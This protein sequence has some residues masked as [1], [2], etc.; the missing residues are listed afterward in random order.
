MFYIYISGLEITVFNL[1]LDSNSVILN[2]VFLW[3]HG[4]T[5]SIR[6]LSRT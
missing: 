4:D 5:N 3:D 1:I 6:E 2:F